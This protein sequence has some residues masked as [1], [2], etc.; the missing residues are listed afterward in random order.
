TLKLN[1]KLKKVSSKII[2]QLLDEK[3][4]LIRQDIISESQILN[5]TY[6]YPGKCKLK[7]I[8]DANGDG[9]WTTGSHFKHR[10]P[11]K[12]IYYSGDV[13]IRSNWDLELEWKVE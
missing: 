11:E 5:Y 8:Y 2:L 10:Q 3:D 1:L 7:I 4:N 13:T 6:L 12:I 9:K